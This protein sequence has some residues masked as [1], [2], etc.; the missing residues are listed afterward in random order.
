MRTYK[1]PL[2]I[3]IG[4]R[5]RPHPG[6]PTAYNPDPYVL[7]HNGEYYAYAT[8]AEGVVAMHSK[9][10]THWT[11]LGYAYRR[12]GQHDYWAPAAFYDN[13]TFYLYVSSR[14]RGE[15]DVHYEF[16]QAATA[17]RPEGPFAYATTLFDTFSI[18]AHVIRDED[19]GLLLLYSTNETCGVD[20]DRPGTVILADRL[21]DPLTPERKPQ[22]LVRPTLDEEIYEE[23]RFGDGRDWHTI[24][25]AFHLRRRGRHYMMYSGNAFTRP[26]YYIG[27]SVADHRDGESIAALDWTKFP[28]D[29]SYVPLL[30]QNERVEGVGHNSV[31]KAPNNVDDWVVYHGRSVTDGGATEGGPSVAGGERRQLRMDPLLWLG[32]RMH[33]PGPSYDERPAPALPGFRDLFDRAAADGLGDAWEPQG[34]EW[35]I[36]GEREELLQRSR[37]GVSRALATGTYSCAVVEV[38]AKWERHHMGGL[39]GA[40]AHYVDEQNYVEVLLDV[41][42]RTIGVYETANG[43]GLQPLV[44]AVPDAARFRFDAYHQLLLHVTGGRVTVEL[45]GV[46]VATRECRGTSG[47]VGLTARYTSARFDGVAVTGRLAWDAATASACASWL[48]PREGR[49]RVAGERLVGRPDGDGDGDGG[50]GTALGVRHPFAGEPSE[51]RFDASGA[52]QGLSL[53]FEPAATVAGAEADA[54]EIA[55]PL[56]EGR[57]ACTIRIR[58]TGGQLDVWADEERLV[59]AKEQRDWG[60]LVIGADRELRLEALEWTALGT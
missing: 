42:R 5:A 48:Q 32:D 34:G 58:H 13:G 10:L 30:R 35:A 36:D 31:T 56:A 57:R 24:E 14:E 41:G 47:R 60:V 12:E 38:N 8:S 11:H 27:Y 44:V 23:N 40:V 50:R 43:V 9:D 45:D 26:L 25:G 49:W 15:E 2:P 53:R 20:A 51:C 17:D 1:N 7:K 28:D 46:A 19:G 54:L 59:S 33:V 16:L 55:V 21:L 39:Y 22:L 4:E 52:L 18:D 6:L 29:D 37:V 3:E